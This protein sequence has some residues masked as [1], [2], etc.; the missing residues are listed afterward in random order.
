VEFH[1][2][3]VGSRT[4]VLENGSDEDVLGVGTYQLRLHGGNK[5][6]VR[7]ALYA[8]GV[9]CSLVSFVSLMR[10]DFS[11]GFHSDG[12]DLFYNGNL[13]WPCYI[14][15]RFHCFGLIQYL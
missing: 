15:R 5:L 3:W 12:L 4:I 7:D 14:E 2:Y 8:P 13:F 1:C 10:I 9:R 6:L 11:F